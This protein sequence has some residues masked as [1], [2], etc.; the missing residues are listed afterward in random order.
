VAAKTITY[1][2]IIPQKCAQLAEREHVPVVI[3]N[4]YQALKAQFKLARLS[5]ADPMVAQ[6]KEAVERLKA[7][8]KTPLQASK[9][10]WPRCK[11]FQRGDQTLRLP[12]Y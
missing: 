2:V 3:E 8:S 12:I 10:Q 9:K 1:P 5:K 6:C 11:Q 7:A 4:R